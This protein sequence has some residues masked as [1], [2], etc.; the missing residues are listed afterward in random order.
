MLYTDQQRGVVPVFEDINRAAKSPSNPIFV[1][2]TKD[3]DVWCHF[4]REKVEMIIEVV[5]VS[6][7]NPSVDGLTKNLA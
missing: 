5:H 6:S 2:R 1:S 7:A 4:E 3:I